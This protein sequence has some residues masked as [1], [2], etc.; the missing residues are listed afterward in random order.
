MSG[1]SRSVWCQSF[2][3][4]RRLEAEKTP[5]NRP[6]KILICSSS[7]GDRRNAKHQLN[8]LFAVP[9]AVPFAAVVVPAAAAATAAARPTA[10]RADVQQVFIL[11]ADRPV[12]LAAELPAV[13]S[14]V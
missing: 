6:D 13:G 2:S 10:G 8:Y 11:P 9:F 5:K 7:L 3:S 12:D 1:S 14:V 4:V